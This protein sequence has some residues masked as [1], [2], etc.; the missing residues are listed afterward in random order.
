MACERAAA[1]D[2]VG[3]VDCPSCGR[4]GVGERS[5]RRLVRSGVSFLLW[6]PGGGRPL[7]LS[8]RRI[9][10]RSY[11]VSMV[12]RRA[13]P[14]ALGVF[15]SSP[16]GSGKRLFSD[17]TIPSGLKLTDSMVSTTGVVIGTYEPAGEIATGSFAL[18]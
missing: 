12:R 14:A 13:E 17:G 2:G 16:I 15:T 18:E 8:R 10:Q 7:R 5:V 11:V 4:P 3:S 9:G 6:G 1:L